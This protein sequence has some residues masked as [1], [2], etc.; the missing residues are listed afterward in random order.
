[1]SLLSPGSPL[2]CVA[3]GTRGCTGV[4]RGGHRTLC[5]VAATVPVRSTNAQCADCARLDRSRSVAA[6]TRADDPQPY[7]VYLAYFGPGLLKVGITAAARG[8]ARLLEQGAVAF[9]RLGTGPLMAARRTEE[10]LGAA[11]GVKDR[12]P[13]R[14]KRAVRAVLPPV[15]ERF[16]ELASL[17]ARVAA[18]PGWPGS[19]ER[20]PFEPVDHT[21]VFGLD[22][23]AARAG[24][25]GISEI[26]GLEDGVTLAGELLGAAGP[27]LHL[28]TESGVLVADARLMAGWRLRTADSA[29][30]TTAP[31]RTLAVGRAETD[32]VQ[33]SLF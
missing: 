8:S 17:H 33:D 4:W 18:L 20:A 24:A 23:L 10:L 13:Y 5:P 31:K 3:D 14:E 26:T 32:G 12:I 27:D 30:G 25:D 7:A 19:M 29:T 1:M 28:G 6:D 11:L 21:G 2:A 22:R 16:A 15:G 9:S